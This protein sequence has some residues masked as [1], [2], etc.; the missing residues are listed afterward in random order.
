MGFF[1]ANLLEI[2][3]HDYK[4]NLKAPSSYLKTSPQFSTNS[5]ITSSSRSNFNPFIYFIHCKLPFFSNFPIF[6]FS[7]LQYNFFYCKCR[8]NCS[9]SR[10]KEE[11]LISLSIQ[12]FSIYYTIPS[13]ISAKQQMPAQFFLPS[14]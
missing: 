10:A 2:T 6:Q 5:T 8:R 4:R 12:L 13:T 14:Q 3:F 7:N 1:F 9:N 11:R